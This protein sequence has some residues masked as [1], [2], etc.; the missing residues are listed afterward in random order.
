MPETLSQLEAEALKRKEKLL[1][2]KRKF[3]GGGGATTTENSSGDSASGSQE[4]GETA[5]KRY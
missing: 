1:Q 5:L 2:M 4:P 3:V